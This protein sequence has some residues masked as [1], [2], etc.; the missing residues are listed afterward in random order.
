MLF[1]YSNNKSIKNKNQRRN[2]DNLTNESKYPC[3]RAYLHSLLSFTVASRG[4]VLGVDGGVG[5]V[6]L[7]SMLIRVFVFCTYADMTGR[8]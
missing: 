3:Q 4:L 6:A 1:H 7:Y 8:N 5:G 2:S